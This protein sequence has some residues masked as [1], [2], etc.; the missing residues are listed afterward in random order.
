M[1]KLKFQFWLPDA[2]SWLIGKVPVL[3]KIEGRRRRGHQRMRWLDG[4]TDAMDMNVGKL[5]EMMRDREAWCAA[6]HGVAKNQ[7]RLGDWTTIASLVPNNITWDKNHG[8]HL[9]VEVLRRSK[10]FTIFLSICLSYKRIHA[11][12]EAPLAWDPGC[13]W[14]VRPCQLSW[15]EHWITVVWG[16]S[17]KDGS[18]SVNAAWLSHTHTTHTPTN[19]AYIPITTQTHS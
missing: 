11:R 3:G 19:S 2:N 1:L 18:L 4:I 5:W 12:R 7:A 15:K 10:Q 9:W 8:C 17:L 14:R 6:V 13:I 16:K